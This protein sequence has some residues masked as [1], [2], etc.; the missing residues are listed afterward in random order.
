MSD[1]NP[2]I[3]KAIDSR[4]RESE[5]VRSAAWQ[6]YTTMI[7]AREPVS[8]I[9]VAR[10]AGVSRDLIYDIPDLLAE[11][12]A[13][14]G[15]QEQPRRNQPPVAADPSLKVKLHHATK[16][17][18]RLSKQLAQNERALARALGIAATAPTSDDEPA[19]LREE[20]IR[21]GADLITERNARER[22]RLEKDEL[23]DELRAAR[24]NNRT[25]LKEMTELR[26]RL[27]RAERAVIRRGERGAK[28]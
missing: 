2:R 26:Q 14:R 7:N 3:G 18:T 5:R 19:A 25:Y 16:E 12:H 20:I 10:R 27:D 11:I 28:A 23:E 13:R 8:V 24:E 6:A 22:L 1:T 21:L 15:G 4:R 17:I 9:G